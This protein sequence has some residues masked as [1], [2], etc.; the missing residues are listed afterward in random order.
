MDISWLFK[1]DQPLTDEKRAYNYGLSFGVPAETRTEPEEDEDFVDWL[2]EK[3]QS[4]DTA[5]EEVEKVLKDYWREGFEHG[6][7]LYD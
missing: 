6:R 3:M 2:A 5:K 1:P 7:T 4:V